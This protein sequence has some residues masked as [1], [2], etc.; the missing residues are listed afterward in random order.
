MTVVDEDDNY[1]TDKGSNDTVKDHD[2]D[3]NTSKYWHFPK[4]GSH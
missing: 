2:D 4:H 3:Q 1:D